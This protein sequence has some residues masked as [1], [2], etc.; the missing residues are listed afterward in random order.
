MVL[1]AAEMLRKD[2]PLSQN[3]P[4]Y[5]A[6]NYKENCLKALEIWGWDSEYLQIALDNIRKEAIINNKEQWLARHIAFKGVILKIQQL[7]YEEID[8]GVLTTKS[9]EFTLELLTYFNLRPALLYGHESGDKASLL[10]QIL[11]ERPIKGFIEDRRTTLETIV[12]TPS[13]SSIPCYLASWGYLK[14][15]D[16][17]N[18]P[19]SIH[20][21]K[22]ENLM[23]PL[24][25]W[26]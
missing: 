5:F 7:S 3:G 16:T 19:S 23:S 18:L 1:L 10:L 15:N 2:S 22:P 13:L 17:K 25:N 9:A 20:L 4:L 8:F 12:N 24:A 6:E 11:K 14:P 21:L 26:P